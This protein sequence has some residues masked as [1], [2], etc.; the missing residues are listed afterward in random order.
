MAYHWLGK[1]VAIGPVIRKSELQL[2]GISA[3]LTKPG[4]MWSSMSLGLSSFFYY[5]ILALYENK[6]V[7]QSDARRNVGIFRIFRGWP[8]RE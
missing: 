4:N 1:T 8:V 3:Y 5:F 2:K 6:Y 7:F